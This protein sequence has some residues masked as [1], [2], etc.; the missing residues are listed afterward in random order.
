[1]PRK[2][3]FHKLVAEASVTINVPVT[4]V[5]EAS[6]KPEIIKEYMFGTEVFTDWKEGSEI[7]W[8][9]EWQGKTYQDKGEIL[10]I[11][12]RKLLQYSHF[13]PVSGLADVPGIIIL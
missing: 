7:M 5:W 8:K 2:Q 9:G 6:V 11:K 1:M 13:S 12:P 10:Q 3:I 4:K